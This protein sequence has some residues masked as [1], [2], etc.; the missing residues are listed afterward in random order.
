MDCG[1]AHHNKFYWVQTKDSPIP[2]QH[3][4]ARPEVQEKQELNKTT[5]VTDN[6]QSPCIDKSPYEDFSAFQSF[7]RQSLGKPRIDPP[8][9]SHLSSLSSFSLPSVGLLDIHAIDQTPPIAPAAGPNTVISSSNT[10]SLNSMGSTNSINGSSSSR[11]SSLRISTSFDRTALS[12]VKFLEA[13]RARRGLPPTPTEAASSLDHLLE[14]DWSMADKEDD[15]CAPLSAPPIGLARRSSFMSPSPLSARPLTGVDVEGLDIRRSS[16]GP[17]AIA[18]SSNGTS[19]LNSSILESS[20]TATS[21]TTSN[22]TGSPLSSPPLAIDTASLNSGHIKKPTSVNTHL[23]LPQ[24]T[25]VSSSAPNTPAAPVSQLQFSPVGANTG[26]GSLWV[27]SFVNSSMSAPTTPMDP[28]VPPPAPAIPASLNVGASTVPAST[29]NLGTSALVTAPA[30]L[31]QTDSAYGSTSS[32]L[33]SK[34]ADDVADHKLVDEAFSHALSNMSLGG[35]HDQ[36]SLMEEQL[37]SS[38]HQVGAR[39]LIAGD[40]DAYEKYSAGGLNSQAVSPI[41]LMYQQLLASQN[42]MA[43]YNTMNVPR[44][45]TPLCR[46]FIAGRCWAGNH[47]RFTHLMGPPPSA[48]NQTTRPICKHFIVG[49]CWAGSLC[50]FAHFPVTAT[51][52]S[53]DMPIAP[54]TGAHHTGAA[55]L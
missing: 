11:H 19:P 25:A 24:A 10:H 35:S 18:T 50:R 28:K 45:P 55:D 12:N 27:L 26:A 40:L 21:P 43:M 44:F 38:A 41:E 8:F 20:T 6:T 47:C 33:S 15:L 54:T 53:H 14:V 1:N 5:P 37:G 13:R 36:L 3:S 32:L 48:T 29:S 51:Q 46:H 23:L 42:P 16:S 49:R 22:A 31:A 39:S 34:A 17:I 4:T 30:P 9:F 52:L 7:S 2:I